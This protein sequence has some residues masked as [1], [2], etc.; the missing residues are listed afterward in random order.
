MGDKKVVKTELGNINFEMEITKMPNN[1]MNQIKH[2]IKEYKIYLLFL[3][4]V[5]ITC[6]SFLVETNKTVGF[7]LV[8]GSIEN[9]FNVAQDGTANYTIPIKVPP[10]R[11]GVSPKLSLEYS[12]GQGNGILGM[13]W[14]IAGLPSI[15]ICSKSIAQDSVNLSPMYGSTVVFCLNGERLIAVSGQYGADG[16]QYSTERN[17]WT[18]ISSHGK[19]QNT[20]LPDYFTLVNKEGESIELGKATHSKRRII[21]NSGSNN[22]IPVGWLVNK[23]SDRNGNFIRFDYTNYDLPGQSYLQSISYTGHSDLEPDKKI[24]FNYEKRQDVLNDYSLGVGRSSILYR[25]ADITSTVENNVVKTYRFHYIYSVTSA[26]SI[27]A[28]ITECGSDNQ[29]FN[30]TYFTLQDGALTT[31]F[32]GQAV[33]EEINTGVC[34]KDS[35]NNNQC[36]DNNNFSTIRY[37]DINGDGVQDIAYRG[38]KGIEIWLSDRG[39]FS[40]NN[41]IVTTICANGSLDYGVCNDGDNFETIQYPDINGDGLDDLMY[42][43][44]EGIQ[45]WFSQGNQFTNHQSTTICKNRSIEY[46]VCNDNDNYPTI[47]SVDINSDG[48]DDLIYRGDQ[49]IQYFLSNGITF[50]SGNHHATDICANHSNK[51]GGCNSDD[52]YSTIQYQDMDSNGYPDIVFRSDH[53]IT[54][55]RYRVNKDHSTGNWSQGFF[56]SVPLTSKI[57]ANGSNDFG[58]CNSEDNYKTIQYPDING[59]GLADLAYRGDDG[60]QYWINNGRDFLNHTSTNICA[61]DSKLYGICNSPDNWYTIS[62]PDINQDGKGDLIYRGDNGIQVWINHQQKFTSPIATDICKNTQHGAPCVLSGSNE[63]MIAFT[64]ITGNAMVDLAFHTDEQGIGF[65]PIFLNYPD[66][67]TE[68]TDGLEKKT[69]ITYKPLTNPDVYTKGEGSVFPVIDVQ[70]PTYVTA[71]HEVQG[72][73]SGANIYSFDHRYQGLKINKHRGLQGFAKSVLTNHQFDSTLTSEYYQSFPLSGY[74]ERRTMNDNTDPSQEKIIS[75]ELWDVHFVKANDIY[76]IWNHNQQTEHYTNGHYNYTLESIR[77]YDEEHRNIIQIE[78]KA[79]SNDSKKFFTCFTYEQESEDRWWRAFYPRSIKTVTQAAAC[80]NDV[81][82]DEKYDLNWRRFL[83]DE[84]MN[85]KQQLTWDNSKSENS[86]VKIDYD[87]Y[88]NAIQYTNPAGVVSTTIY[89]LK[90]ATFPISKTKGHLTQH[91]TYD[92]NFGIQTSFTDANNIKL[93]DIPATGID[94]LGRVTEVRKANP[95]TAELNPHTVITRTKGSFFPMDIATYTRTQWQG[96]DTPDNSWLWT[97][98]AIDSFGRNVET[99]SKAYDTQTERVTKSIVLNKQ[100]LVEKAYWPVYLHTEGPAC[101]HEVPLSEGG[102]CVSAP[103]NFNTYQY[104]SQGRLKKVTRP[105]GS[106]TETVFD[107]LDNRKVTQRLE[108]PRQLSNGDSLVNWSTVYS[109]RGKV[110]QQSSPSGATSSYHYDPIDRLIT[111]TG[112][113]GENTHFTYNSLNQRVSI[114]KPEIGSIAYTYDGS[115][116]LATKIDNKQQ[117]IAYHYDTSGR[118]KTK[119]SYADK[120]DPHPTAT[121]TYFYDDPETENGGGKITEIVSPTLTTGF[122]YYKNGKLKTTNTH[123]TLNELTGNQE[124]EVFHQGFAYDPLDRKKYVTYPDLSIA[125]YTYRN[126]TDGSLATIQLQ[127]KGQGLPLDYASYGVPT[128]LGRPVNITYGNGDHTH[129]SYNQVGRTQNVSIVNNAKSLLNTTYEWNKA[130]K[131]L[132]QTDNLNRQYTQWFSDASSA[133]YDEDGRLNKAAG[134]YASST[135]PLEYA[136]D[137]ANNLTQRSELQFTYDPLKKN[138]VLAAYLGCQPNDNSNTPCPKAYSYHYDENGNLERKET[139][140]TNWNYKYNVKGQLSEVL[141]NNNAVST[142]AYGPGSRRVFKANSTP[143]QGMQKTYFPSKYYEALEIPDGQ[144]IATKYLHDPYGKFAAISRSNNMVKTS[145]TQVSALRPGGNGYGVPE[146]NNVRFF[147]KNLIASNTL[148]TSILDDQITRI[149]YQPYGKIDL[150][151]S[152]GID[153]FREKF[154]GKNYDYNTGL[155][156]FGARYYDAT[157][158]R[159]ITPDPAM[160][161]HSPYIYTNGDPLTQIDPSG[162]FS[163]GHLIKDAFHVFKKVDPVGA[164][165]T[166]MLAPHMYKALDSGHLGSAKSFFSGFG[167]EAANMATDMINFS[168]QQNFGAEAFAFSKITGKRLAIPHPFTINSDENF[169]AGIFEVGSLLAAPEADGEVAGE[170][171]AAREGSELSGSLAEKANELRPG[172]NVVRSPECQGESCGIINIHGEPLCFVA[173]TAIETPSGKRSIENIQVGDLVLSKNELTGKQTYKPVKKVFITPLNTVGS[174]SLRNNHGD[175]DIMGVT[176]NHPYFVVD[177]GFIPA[178]G[179]TKGDSIQS[180]NGGVLIVNEPWMYQGEETTYNFEVADI[181]NYFAGE[182]GAWVHNQCDGIPSDS[183]LSAPG[184]PTG[185]DSSGPPSLLSLDS[186]SSEPPTLL[187]SESSSSGPP[188]LLSSES[189][190]S[191]NVFD[192]PDLLNWLNEVLNNVH[193]PDDFYGLTDSE[194]D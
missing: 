24:L 83:Y 145:T 159:F 123:F 73:T 177:K 67:V 80:D 23:I 16:T 156:Y 144:K 147:H 9:E 62:F 58:K 102:T 35:N 194:E 161:F 17:N 129:I 158:G 26:R 170:E 127:E 146:A 78:H 94:S 88:G 42:R 90:T 143:Q 113:L 149:V 70:I 160:Q 169:G 98:N 79:D 34:K 157:M 168:L 41:R 76:T 132:S 68:I 74:L 191:E 91:M 165:A 92:P 134:P 93:W 71:H 14:G 103:S 20:E 117:K 21:N 61:N 36:R 122:S 43:G 33:T 22:L 18:R 38:N 166:H 116:G 112:P 152:E 171:I 64:D 108:D 59:D 100:G 7:E 44:D 126:L 173:G 192:L 114:S 85:I 81:T 179:L 27:I 151:N 137:P 66:L 75:V 175:V 106:I 184:S 135:A 56:V 140:E 49:G 55:I 153:N 45:I 8:A 48:W 187:S 163:F 53:G 133:W 84:N 111:S 121:D 155:S 189:S 3:T 72:K 6:C 120:N 51:Y 148:V 95:N 50:N 182:L 46:G 31:F 138:Q 39:K 4:T 124:N 10:G 25:L 193:N 105:D 19:D 150:S 101:F 128:S 30:P 29:C 183:P 87:P 139:A 176:A 15:S 1:Y 12:S 186:S 180:I 52:N 2:L 97:R 131:M 174:L 141:L 11:N 65:I 99:R 142:F 115:G 63:S 136:Y 13:G 172:E 82:W 86:I 37:P 185:P 178:K 109:S 130:G 125:T 119:A 77:T 60:I 5:G 40:A 107:P 54:V 32:G 181:H 96:S 188:T 154:A 69:T 164:F 89:D 190:A 167:K 162:L 118:L 47:R 28:E 57:C 104:D 110:L